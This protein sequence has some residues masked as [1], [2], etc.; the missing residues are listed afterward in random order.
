METPFQPVTKI[1]STTQALGDDTPS[2]RSSTLAIIETCEVGLW[3]VGPGV[4]H[5]IEVEEV[6]VVLAGSATITVEGHDP[7]EV[8]PGDVVHLSEG[9]GTAW[10]VH[11]RLRKIYVTPRGEPAT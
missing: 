9:A 1:G 3:E 10:E 4:E 11:E 7:V 2:T 6:F 5:D 8:G